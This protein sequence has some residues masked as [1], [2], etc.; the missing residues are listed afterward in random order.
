MNNH[1]KILKRVLGG[2]APYILYQ[3]QF[4]V[5]IVNLCR[6][7]NLPTPMPYPQKTKRMII[8]I[9]TKQGMYFR[10]S[11]GTLT[12]EKSKASIILN[13][14]PKNIELF[15]QSILKEHPAWQAVELQ[16]LP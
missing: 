5:S 1:T 7:L 12:S 9:Y 4:R 3:P 2:K 15:K 16:D 11:Y 10:Q 14:L 13:E 6:Q 8:A